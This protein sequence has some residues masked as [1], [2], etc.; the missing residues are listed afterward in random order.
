M[1]HTIHDL[2][3]GRFAH[4]HTHAFV[5]ISHAHVYVCL[6]AVKRIYLH[7]PPTLRY[8]EGVAEHFPMAMAD[9]QDVLDRNVLQL[10]KREHV[11]LL[12]LV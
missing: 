9:D 2:F 4:T 5:C 7:C 12:A 8:V 6:F 3:V 11:A 10:W 1:W